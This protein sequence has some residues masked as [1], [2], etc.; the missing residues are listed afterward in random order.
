MKT[1]EP[2]TAKF[3]NVSATSSAFTLIELLVVIAIIAI[4]AAMLLPA[5]SKAKLRA[6]GISCL[7]NMK[8][9]GYAEILY[10]G[11]NAEQLSPNADYKSAGQSL[12]NP[13]W[14]AGWM[15]DASE[16]TNIDLMIGSQWVPFG[17]IGAYT[18]NPGVY[19]CPADQSVM[20]GSPKVRSCS[21]NGAIGISA[22]WGSQGKSV[23]KN[24]NE[25]YSK[26]TDFKKLKPVNA[27]MFLDE[28]KEFL[29]DGWCWP[30]ETLYHVGN[31][32]AINHGNSSSISFADGH[33]ELHRWSGSARF[34]NPPSPGYNITIVPI[35]GDP[36]TDA[37]WMWEHF[38]AK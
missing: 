30:P 13:S 14:V 31:F 5:L 24:G 26:T 1:P 35:P 37:Q 18:K 9:L 6:Q 22:S 2:S 27:V 20:S 15:Q 34:I 17:S 28:R 11:D 3:P 8:Q 16:A 25:H 38:T 32:P 7:S 19:K 29:D 36:S 23:F 12:A 10:A 21:L 4:L 33:A